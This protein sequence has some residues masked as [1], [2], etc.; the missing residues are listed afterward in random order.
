M[1]DYI[2]KFNKPGVKPLQWHFFEEAARQ[3]IASRNKPVY[4]AHQASFNLIINTKH[5]QK[6]QWAA[7]LG[8]SSTKVAG[9]CY[10]IPDSSWYFSRYQPDDRVAIE[11]L[12]CLDGTPPYFDWTPSDRL[13]QIVAAEIYSRFLVFDYAGHRHLLWMIDPANC[14]RPMLQHEIPF[15]FEYADVMYEPNKAEDTVKC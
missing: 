13:T 4:C 3:T 14:D 1:S 15:P 7:L 6:K 10:Q 5:I 12:F 2:F 8:C 11:L 9:L